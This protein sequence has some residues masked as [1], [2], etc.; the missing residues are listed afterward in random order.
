MEFKILNENNQLNEID[1]KSNSKIQVIYK[2]S[3]QCGISMMTDRTLNKELKEIST[4][5]MD[6][7]YLDLLRYRDLSST[8]SMRYNVEHESPQILIIKEGKCIYDASH[9]D[10]SLQKAL[11]EIDGL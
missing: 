1:L 5:S 9:S 7:Y 6:V 10:V 4:D 2:H 11:Q 8:I 3:T